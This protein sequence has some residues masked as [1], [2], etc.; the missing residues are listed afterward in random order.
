MLD[1]L[2]AP[3]AL[4]RTVQSMDELIDFDE[5]ARRLGVSRAT[6]VRWQTAG[7]FGEVDAT[8]PKRHDRAKIEQI[9]VRDGLLDPETLKPVERQAATGKGPR[10]P[11]AEPVIG[12]DGRTRLY[13]PHV[14]AMF[15]V[16]EGTVNAW[17]KP[18]GAGG[19]MPDPDERDG[20]KPVWYEATL[21]AWGRATGRLDETGRPTGTWS[22]AGARLLNKTE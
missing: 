19:S 8:R 10:K 14:A 1:T 22:W 6:I 20:R 2:L 11:P 18:S 16:E 4:P 3:A 17:R 21:R 13:I 9:G 7:R 15:G 5:I 12:D